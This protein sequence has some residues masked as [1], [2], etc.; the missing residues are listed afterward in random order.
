M[1]IVLAVQHAAHVA[2]VAAAIYVVIIEAA[3]RPAKKDGSI[4]T[5]DLPALL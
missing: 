5:S 2:I 4:S 1:P 3:T